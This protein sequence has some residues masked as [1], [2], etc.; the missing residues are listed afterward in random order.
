M[1]F[2]HTRESSSASVKSSS[3]GIQFHR[4]LLLLL[5]SHPFKRQ[6][7]SN[8]QINPHFQY[9]ITR[10]PWTAFRARE[11]WHRG[12]QSAKV[13]ATAVTRALLLSPAATEFDQ[14]S[15]IEI[16]CGTRQSPSLSHLIVYPC[17]PPPW[18]SRQTT[19]VTSPF[20]SGCLV[21]RPVTSSVMTP[22]AATYCGIIKRSFNPQMERHSSSL[23]VT[24]WPRLLLIAVLGL[25]AGGSGSLSFPSVVI[26]TT[27]SCMADC[28]CLSQTQVSVLSRF[29][30]PVIATSDTIS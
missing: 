19:D 24:P 16:L 25:C 30:S 10:L 29:S 13:D 18:S 14:E 28:I 1:Q 3:Q 22:E 12:R 27:D 17:L 9:S 2:R 15:S 8:S 4:L 23:R 21:A 6:L 7:P 26:A 5:R 20:I 11:H